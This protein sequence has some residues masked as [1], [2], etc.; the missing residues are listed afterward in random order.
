MS[1]AP[2][3]R[4]QPSRPS[5]GKSH[6]DKLDMKAHD[7]SEHIEEAEHTMVHFDDSIESTAPS[8]AVWLITFTV[9]MGG[10]LFGNSTYRHLY[11]LGSFA[12]LTS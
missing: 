6:D 7:N 12:N 2:S 8:K 5:S 3:E 11:K 9:A 1:Q 4:E 10:F